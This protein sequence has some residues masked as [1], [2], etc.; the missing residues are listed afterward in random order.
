[1]PLSLDSVV[2]R[3]AYLILRTADNRE[4]MAAA[5]KPGA[6]AGGQVRL[7]VVLTEAL[8]EHVRVRA[9]QTRKSRSAYIRD[10]VFAD[11]QRTGSGADS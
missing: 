4:R 6:D 8:A 9:F 11:A 2:R 1:M 10:L 3:C 7:S 5:A